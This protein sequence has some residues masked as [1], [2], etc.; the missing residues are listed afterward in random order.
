MKHK[1]Q[2]DS[3]AEQRV[4]DIKDSLRKTTYLIAVIQEKEVEW[5]KSKTEAKSSG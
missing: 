5:S 1:R 3:N 2:E 4:R